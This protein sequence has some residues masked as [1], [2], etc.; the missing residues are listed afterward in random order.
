MSFSDRQKSSKREEEGKRRVSRE[1][2][3]EEGRRREE[4]GKEEKRRGRSIAI[5]LMYFEFLKVFFIFLGL[6]K[7]R[8]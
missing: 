8:I 4:E 7:L 6:K 1:E 5:E 3:E 2:E